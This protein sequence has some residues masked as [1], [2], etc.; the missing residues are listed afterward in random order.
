MTGG[1]QFPDQLGK[2]LDGPVTCTYDKISPKSTNFSGS[3]A[4]NQTNPQA[5]GLIWG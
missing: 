3:T 5:S 2:V 1:E 4:R